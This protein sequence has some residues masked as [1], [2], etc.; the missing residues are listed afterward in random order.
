MVARI[1]HLEAGQPGLD[2]VAVVEDE[3][4]QMN[5]TIDAR[6]VQ[7]H[8]TRIQVGTCV[9]LRSPPLFPVAAWDHHIVMHHRCITVLRTETDAPPPAPSPSPSQWSHT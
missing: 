3:T 7:T 5:A 9:I 1:I 8:G 4:G 6:A 2:V